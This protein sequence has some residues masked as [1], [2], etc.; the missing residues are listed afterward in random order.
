[1]ALSRRLRWI[2]RAGVLVLA[3]ATGALWL[4]WHGLGAGWYVKQRSPAELEALLRPA[5]TVLRP[6]GAGP[7]PAVLMFHGC[8]GIHEGDRQ[9]ARWFVQQGFVVVQVDS[10]GPRGLEHRLRDVCRGR[11]LWGRER[12]GDVLVTL[13]EVRQWPF[14]DGKRLVLAGWSHGGWTLMDLLAL[15]L[16]GPPQRLPTSLNAAPPRGLDGVAAVLLVYPYAGMGSLSADAPWRL[17]VPTLMLLSGKDTVVPTEAT[18]KTAEFQ[19]RH[20]RSIDVHVYDGLDHC[21]DQVGLE[22]RFHQDAAATADARARVAALLE[23]VRGGA[24]APPAVRGSAAP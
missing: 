21:F 13:D 4:L 23:R 1:M 22:P 19:R 9:W 10:L 8:G 5:T 18:L 12:A 16:V 2:L 3:L 14:V 6:D 7:F 15:D 11:A 17:D 20:G 24:A